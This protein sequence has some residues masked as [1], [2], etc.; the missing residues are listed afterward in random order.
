MVHAG[1]Y[2]PSLLQQEHKVGITAISDGNVITSVGLAK[3][4]SNVVYDINTGLMD[5]TTAEDHGFHKGK[6][7][8]KV[9]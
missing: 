1:V 5:I 9:L 8:L 7:I 6:F 2:D 4:I 3:T